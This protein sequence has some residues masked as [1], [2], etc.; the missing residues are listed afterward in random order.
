MRYMNSLLKEQADAREAARALVPFL[1]VELG[2]L[3]RMAE[4]IDFAF[5]GE[6]FLREPPTTPRNRKRFWAYFN[7]HTQVMKQMFLVI[8]QFIKI[9]GCPAEG[10][11]YWLRLVEISKRS[12]RKPS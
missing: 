7:M 6:P 1:I 3:E 5:A 10:D 8:D 4:K 9:F 2:R 11:E 12:P